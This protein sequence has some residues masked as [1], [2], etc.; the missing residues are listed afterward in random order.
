M[1]RR[2]GSL[3][4]GA[5]VLVAIAACDPLAPLGVLTDEQLLESI[6]FTPD[7]TD[8]HVGDSVHVAVKKVGKGGGTVASG[9]VVLTVGNPLVISV[10][11]AGYVKGLRVGTTEVLGT[12]SGRRGSAVIRV[13]P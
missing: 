8:L 12:L 9:T 5:V 1:T 3:V 4:A 10:S 6:A 13:I 7:S 11:N 2:L